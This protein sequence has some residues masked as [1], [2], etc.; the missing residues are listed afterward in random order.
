MV[1]IARKECHKLMM[2]IIYHT[3]IRRDAMRI[4]QWS[5]LKLIKCRGFVDDGKGGVSY[6][7]PMNN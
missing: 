1:N 3:G 2:R 4:L 5:H 6:W 7:F